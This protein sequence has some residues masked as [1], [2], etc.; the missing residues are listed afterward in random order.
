MLFFDKK[1]LMCIF[2]DLIWVQT[3]CKGYQH[4]ALDQIGDEKENS[5]IREATH[6][7]I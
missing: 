7:T 3:V 5:G 1:K 2:I 6:W 4:M